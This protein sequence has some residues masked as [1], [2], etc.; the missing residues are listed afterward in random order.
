MPITLAAHRHAEYRFLKTEKEGEGGGMK[1][2][3]S[4]SG[5]RSSW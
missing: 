1:Q 2:E 5:V 4:F 3:R